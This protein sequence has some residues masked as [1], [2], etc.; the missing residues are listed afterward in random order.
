MTKVEIDMLV[1]RISAIKKEYYSEEERDV[2]VFRSDIKQEILDW[3]KR[4]MNFMFDELEK[5]IMELSDIRH[6]ELGHRQT[7]EDRAVMLPV[8]KLKQKIKDLRGEK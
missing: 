4:E 2:F 6:F 7:I 1:L 3:H 8:I 5:I